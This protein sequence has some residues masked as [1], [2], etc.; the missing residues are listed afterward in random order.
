M[1]LLREASSSWARFSSQGVQPADPPASL[2]SPRKVRRRAIRTTRAVYDANRNERAWF[3]FFTATLSA[4]TRSRS[5]S[6]PFPVSH[7]TLSL[8]RHASRARAQI[9]IVDLLKEEEERAERES[10]KRENTR[11]STSGSARDLGGGSEANRRRSDAR[12]ALPTHQETIADDASAREIIQTAKL[13]N[14][15]ELGHV[16]EDVA[17]RFQFFFTS[18]FRGAHFFSFSRERTPSETRSEARLFRARPLTHTFPR[19][20]R[21][22]RYSRDSR[23]FHSTTTDADRK[24]LRLPSRW[25]TIREVWTFSGNSPCARRTPAICFSVR[26]VGGGTSLEAQRPMRRT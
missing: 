5:A 1:D 26:R 23:Y 2:T 18:T 19:Y 25:T 13:W 17:V 24:N 22:S 21:Y 8:L 6:S 7:L 20:S 9:S 12:S 16:M 4:R 10:Q 15:E 3:L 11:A 14:E